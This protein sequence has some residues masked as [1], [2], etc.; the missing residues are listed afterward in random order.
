MAI[1]KNGS[2]IGKYVV[3]RTYSAGVHFGVL[4]AKS[5][6]EVTLTDARR[7]W[8]W[9]GAF[10][11]SEVSQTGITGGKVSVAIPEIAIMQAIEVI[12]TSKE[13]EKCLRGSKAHR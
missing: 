3:V 8:S 13:A 9:S 11:L 5:G 7:L 12:P 10:T 6:Q 4:A 1:K 2:M